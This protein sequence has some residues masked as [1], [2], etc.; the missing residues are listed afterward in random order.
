MGKLTAGA[1]ALLAATALSA[2]TAPS[3]SAAKAPALPSFSGCGELA[4]F[5]REAARTSPSYSWALPVWNDEARIDPRQQQPDPATLPRQAS[6]SATQDGYSGDEDVI[7][8]DSG[9][10]VTATPTSGGSE[11]QSGS[12][13]TNVQEAAVDEPDSAKVVGSK[14]YLVVGDELQI[15]ETSGAVPVTIGRLKL[16]AFGGVM[17]IHGS[18]LLLIGPAGTEQLGG[19]N[20]S[21]VREIDISDATR[22]TV[23]RSLRVPGTITAA[24]VHA[25]VARIVVNSTADYPVARDL[26]RGL[27]RSAARKLRS[28]HFVPTTRLRSN[29]TGRT[30]NRNLV[31]C[32][33]VR[34]PSEPSG[35][36]L[37]TVLT[38]DLER[39]LIEPGRAAVL[40]TAE[41]IYAS[42]DALIVGTS[43]WPAWER[44]KP[45]DDVRTELHRFAYDGRATRYDGGGE[46]EGFLL[47][48]F[49]L[50]D[51]KGHLRVATTINHPWGGNRARA[52]SLLT[53]LK[54]ADGRLQHVGQLRGLGPDEQIYS[55]RLMGDRGYVVTFRETDPLYVLDLSDP[56][57]PKT[58]GELKIP[59]FSSYLH[60]LGDDLLLG[61]GQDATDRGEPTGAQISLFDVADPTAPKRL[62]HHKPFTGDEYST[63]LAEKD[64]H[65]F[66]WW[67]AGGHLYL[68]GA[69]ETYNETTGEYLTESPLIALAPSR[70]GGLP[71]TGRHEHGAPWDRP[72]IERV[73][74][75]AGK[76]I[77]I[78]DLGVS[79]AEQGTL[80]TTGFMPF[81]P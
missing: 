29:V 43:R 35:T 36:D 70:A 13:T 61:V 41:T 80:T 62:A 50:S 16:P 30:Y 78:S 48:R 19:Q 63:L 44:S 14:L 57:A 75:A 56:T 71:E 69:S 4:A 28:H 3:A 66:L 58:T 67:P 15:I 2:A 34:H 31:S 51:Y 60:P 81:V 45:N 47:N 23:L 55:A 46:V 11:A 9:A 64:P 76:V 5:G 17:V 37:L 18:K 79:T 33:K 21:M 49:S 8:E 10:A 68:P 54:P 24:R 38:V 53:V 26:Y 20:E 73:A 72:E 40:A 25:G 42:S 6:P 77:A 27:S 39:G 65:A 22:P 59:G 7:Q 52:E 1:A 32:G 74:I 12:S